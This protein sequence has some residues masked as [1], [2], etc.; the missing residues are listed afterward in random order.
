[1]ALESYS[2]AL[3]LSDVAAIHVNGNS[4]TTYNCTS[5][6]HRPK[7]RLRQV[8]SPTMSVLPHV[9]GE[10]HQQQTQHR[11]HAERHRGAESHLAR[12][13]AQAVGIRSH[14]VRGIGR[15]TAG[16]HVDELKVEE[17]END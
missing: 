1:M 14:Q 10:Q 11:H 13:H 6:A 3:A 5:G 7:S 15:A 2:S 12:A 9:E 16:E 4:A 8:S 17:G